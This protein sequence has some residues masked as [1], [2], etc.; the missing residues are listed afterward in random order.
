MCMTFWFGILQS[1][2]FRWM[3]CGHLWEKKDKNCSDEERKEGE[4]GSIWDHIAIDPGSKL[5]V[6]MI[7]GPCRD[8]IGSNAS[9]ALR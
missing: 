9:M 8:Q 1:L 3:K 6:S 4:A 2:K 7:Q 5:I